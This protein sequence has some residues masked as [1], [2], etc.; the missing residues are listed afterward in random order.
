[1][2]GETKAEAGRDG[3]SVSR[4]VG[5]DIRVHLP[6]ADAAAYLGLSPRMLEKHRCY[7]T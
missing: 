6:T 2:I 5:Y 3:S 4:N 7:G 1:M